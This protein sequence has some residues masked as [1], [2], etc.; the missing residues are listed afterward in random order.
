MA[1]RGKMLIRKPKVIAMKVEIENAYSHVP[2]RGGYRVLV[3]RLWPRGLSKARLALD[4]WARELAPS[5]PLRQWF[6]HD[7]TRWDEFCARYRVE[8]REA[9]QRARL[10]ALLDAAGDGPLRL[11]HAAHDA[12]HNHALVLCTRLRRLAASA[13][14]AD[15]G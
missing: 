5:T 11:I 9:A 15:R 8:L 6:G 13:R 14:R 3:D 4:A 2:M 12:E 7:P 10:R 1:A